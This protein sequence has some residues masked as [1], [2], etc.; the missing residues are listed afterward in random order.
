MEKDVFVGGASSEIEVL[1]FRAGGNSYAMNISDV[2]EI[3]SYE[4]KPTPVPNSHPFIEGIIM[5]RDFL[6]SIVNF[7][8]SL[9]LTGEDEDRN[10]MIIITSINDLNIAIH[11]DSVSGIHSVAASEFMKPGEKLTTSQRDVVTS[12]LNI[13]DRKI[14]VIDLIKLFTIINPKVNVV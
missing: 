8:A 11:V 14:E 5:P 4:I 13:E 6:I 1:E 2:K 12:I 10:E 7:G 9:M 3:L